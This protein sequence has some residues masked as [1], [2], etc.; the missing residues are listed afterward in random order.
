MEQVSCGSA[1]CR[2][3]VP[4]VHAD[5]VH[6]H[7]MALGR[8]CREAAPHCQQKYDMSAASGEIGAAYDV[9]GLPRQE[10]SIHSLDV[11]MSTVITPF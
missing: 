1:A 2:L 6:R 3:C 9:P 8:E 10:P 11:H 4:A 7:R 5:S